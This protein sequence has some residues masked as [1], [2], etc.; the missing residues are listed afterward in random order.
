MKASMKKIKVAIFLT[1]RFENKKQKKFS[2]CFHFFQIFT[3]SKMETRTQI[4]P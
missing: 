4:F 3:T 1:H 2:E